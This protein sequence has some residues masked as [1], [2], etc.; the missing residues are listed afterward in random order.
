M[1]DK[2]NIF[3]AYHK[4]FYLLKNE[5]L[6]PLHV[7]RDSLDT[8]NEENALKMKWLSEQMPGDNTGDNISKLNPYYCELTATYWIWKN[9]K[10]EYVGLVH[11]RRLFDFDGTDDFPFGATEE[12]L[13]E[14]LKDTDV[15]LP[16]RM[17]L[18][19]PS[20]YHQFLFNHDGRSLDYVMDYIAKT[21]PEMSVEVD[22]IKTNKQV[23]FWNMLIARK[24][25]FDD[26]AAWLFDVLSAYDK[27][28]EGTGQEKSP[29][30]NG[31]LSERLNNIYFNYLI[32]N[33]NLRYKEYPTAM[34][35][36]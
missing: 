27:Y 13:S 33:K 28:M 20:I 17:T 22:R 18:D 3:V 35:S 2:I 15:I 4:P 14:I 7:G 34:L 24:P 30:I 32:N 8:E 29:R 11:Y 31:F 23:W 16:H 26:Y 6:E 10:S 12:N 1:S 5:V 25:V 21:Y 36:E 9:V 19:E